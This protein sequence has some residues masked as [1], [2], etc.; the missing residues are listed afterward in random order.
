MASEHP[1]MP[2]ETLQIAALIGIIILQVAILVIL[3]L[4]RPPASLEPKLDDTE[5]R[6]REEIERLRAL[7]ERAQREQAESTLREFNALR[8]D[9]KD[10]LGTRITELQAVLAEAA[11]TARREQNERLDAGQKIVADSLTVARRAQDERLDRVE[12]AQ[13]EFGERFVAGME[14]QKTT[15]ADLSAALVKQQA[16]TSTGLSRTLSERLDA[17][18]TE[19]GETLQRLQSNTSERLDLMR[20]DNEKA[21]EKVRATVDEKLQKTLET[22]LGEQFRTVTEQ[23]ERVSRGLGEMQGLAQGVGDLKRVLTNVKSRG[24]FGEVQLGA[25]LEQVLSPTQYERNAKPNPAS[26]ALVEY[27]I[28]LPGKDG[29]DRPVYLPIDA[30]FPVEDY[31]RL[32]QALNDGDRD[33]LEKARRDLERRLTSEARTIREKYINPPHTTDFAI[34]FLPTEG[35]YAE[36]I[37]MPGILDRLQ[38]D[39]RVVLAGPTTLYAILNSLQMGFRTLAIEKRS[40]EVWTLLSAVKTEF[41]KFGDTLDKVQKKIDSASREFDQVGRRSRAI[42]RKLRDVHELDDASQ[43]AALLG[44]EEADSDDPESADFV[45]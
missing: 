32:Q 15:L 26:D 38:T 44:E 37:R 39:S 4:R 24:T 23:L 7:L 6:L 21:L 13:R 9:L 22:R 28:R 27:A 45:K 33:G 42:T 36:A 11:L 19:L 30:K 1:I 31:E 16:E 25:L 18:R 17:L 40:S 34:L 3:L 5:R 41:G 43:A 12:T 35:L 14:L 10:S 20:Q 8:G 2:P 29:S